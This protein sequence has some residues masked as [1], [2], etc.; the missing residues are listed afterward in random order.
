MFLENRA[1]HQFLSIY[2]EASNTKAGLVIVHGMGVLPDWGLIGRLRIAL[3]D[4]GYTTL[5]VQM[6]VLAQAAKTDEYRATFRDAGERL[7]IAT[8][9]LRAKG[10][11]KTAI[12]SH[13]MGSRM[14]HY[15]LNGNATA[16]VSAWVC[17]GWISDDQDFR[18][19]KLPV[20]DLNGEN[21]LAAV[22]RGAKRRAASL[23][24]LEGS[25][26]IMAPKADRAR[27][28]FAVWRPTPRRRL[29]QSHRHVY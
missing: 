24:A 7:K 26:Q 5:S 21:D 16:P 6:P 9:F 11:A 4:H 22:L 13:S 3:E 2:T 28:W 20:L 23:K 25:Q 10:Y 27:Y 8:D 12:V 29:S 19:V 18:H 15:Y 17:I 14:T 1:G